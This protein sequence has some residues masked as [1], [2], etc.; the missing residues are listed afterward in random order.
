MIFPRIKK[1]KGRW[2]KKGGGGGEI[3]LDKGSREIIEW[4]VEGESVGLHKSRN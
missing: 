4:R 3:S 2:G 1:E